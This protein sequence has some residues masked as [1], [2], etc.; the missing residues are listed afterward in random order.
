V[1]NQSSS[2]DVFEQVQSGSTKVGVVPF[3]NSTNG[4][5]VFTLDDLADRAGIFPNITVVGEIF[6][7]VHHYLVG[8]FPPSQPAA[9]AV[10][11][12]NGSG[13]CTP[14]ASD[15]TPLK[16]RAKPICS[17]HHVKRLYSHPQAFGQCNAFTAAYLKGVEVFEASSTSKAAEIVAADETG[18]WAAISSELAADLHP[19]DV[20]AKSIEDRE[21]NTTRFLV[22]ATDPTIQER[23]DV[24]KRVPTDNGKG[25]G[26]KSM[27]SFT[28]PHS[29]PGALAEALSCF[30][31]FEVNLTSINS[32]P[33]LEQPFHYLFFVEFEGKRGE[34]RVEGALEKV[35]RVA[36]GWRWLGSWERYR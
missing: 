17:L 29:S 7:D 21:D 2:S 34:G 4:S 16:P 20:L 27:I 1:T 15:P 8:R 22:I 11:S 9:S 23:W 31:A 26:S 30:K 6:V 14:T 32:R 10:I 5:V 19:V 3:E 28:V 13:T 18:T 25:L 33:S 35:G 24:R 12:P 36:E